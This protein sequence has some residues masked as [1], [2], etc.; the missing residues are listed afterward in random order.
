MSVVITPDEYGSTDAYDLLVA[1]SDFRIA[2]D[3]RLVRALLSDPERTMPGILRYALEIEPDDCMI[4][5]DLIRIFRAM[6]DPLPALPF[7]IAEM[8]AYPDEVTEDL[9]A[10]LARIGK[11]AVQPLLDLHD[12]IEEGADDLLFELACLGIPDS[13]ILDR[14]RAAP[15]EDQPLLLQMYEE[16]FQAEPETGPEAD[17]YD[18]YADYEETVEPD[19]EELPD[20]DLAKFL[21]S[22]YEPHRVSALR[23]KQY[24][25]HDVEERRRILAMAKRDPSLAVRCVAWEALRDDIADLAVQQ[26]FRKAVTDRELSAVEL[27]SVAL[28]AAYMYYDVPAIGPL[29]RAAYTDMA[30]RPKALE[31]MWRSADYSFAPQVM[32][33]LDE[34]LPDEVRRHAIEAAGMLM[35]E[36]ALPE[37]EAALLDERFREQA[38]HAW[39]MAAPGKT[40]PAGLDDLRDRVEDLAN[41]LSEEEEAIVNTACEMRL[42]IL[43]KPEPVVTTSK[44]G[45]NEPCPCG[46]GKKY[47]KCCG[48]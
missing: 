46:S 40:T 34:L 43:G 6:P 41:G 25:E 27:A 31:A 30:L 12:T 1:A 36:R 10:V 16:H 13:R 39:I 8:R 5:E 37:I 20:G 42:S 7:L 33:S 21:D 9:S 18:I 23:A 47:K 26:A 4:D 19:L 17:P 29:I 2:F 32:E 22:S 11:P 15:E 48:G 24:R 28:G 35:I 14:I 45:R 44:V 3:R 38:L